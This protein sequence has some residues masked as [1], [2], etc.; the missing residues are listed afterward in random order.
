MTATEATGT[1]SVGTTGTHGATEAAD[2]EA[3]RQR[4]RAFLREHATGAPPARRDTDDRGAGGLTVAR[5]FQ[6]KL[7]E[8]GL[9]G[10]TYPKEHGGQG[11]TTEH[12]RVWRE[13]AAKFPLMTV[14]LAV[15]H[16]MCTPVLAEFG[17]TEQKA[18]YLAKL[19]SGE[20]VWCQMFSEPGAGSDVASLQTR[21]VRD[22]GEWVLNGQKVWTTLAHL[23]ERGIIL[24]RT[25]P[26]RPK[27][28]GISM[29]I[30]D[31]RAPGV[32]VR[33]IHQID[34]G[35]GFN[36]VFFSD[37]RIP[38]DHLIPPENDG[39]RLATAML[40]YE[41]V[42]IGTGQQGGIRHES[43]DA[44]IRTARRRGALGDPVIRQ[45]L[46]RLYSAEV[47]QSL[48]SAMTRARVKAGHAPGPGGS[49]GKL[50]GS[51]I[52]AMGR[53]IGLAVQGVGGVAWEDGDHQGDRWAT[54][55]LTSFAASIAGG[56]DEIQKNIIGDRVLGL[57]R[58]PSV[59]RD[60]PFKDLPLGT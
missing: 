33:A 21:A 38:A 51:R 1:G 40:M 60:V 43:A 34:G 44:L 12:E 46:M 18:R 27:H 16:G 15:S 31:M 19:I 20:E 58:E 22:G 14:G 41:R 5:D 53:S 42:A 32:E 28:G 23:S 50:A 48:V 25:D 9:A 7:T 17:T 10:L 13:E 45:E 30:V 55:A 26:E 6:R 29:F 54:L 47:C 2:L 8:A 11:L 35:R 57:P 24:A 36:E 56:T 59:D 39:W 49:L 52:A 3:F 4:C 37:V